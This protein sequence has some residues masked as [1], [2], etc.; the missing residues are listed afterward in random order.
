VGP[1]RY[2]KIAGDYA[3]LGLPGQ[4]LS[5]DINVVPRAGDVHATAQQTGLELYRLVSEA[6]RAF[7][8]I[9]FYSEGTIYRQDRGL[10]PG[11][12]ASTADVELRGGEATVESDQGVELEVGD[13]PHRVRMD[14]A[15]WPACN[16][17]AVLVP[18]GKHEIAWEA[19]TSEDE[20]FL[21]RDI[22]AVL[23]GASAEPGALTVRYK[24]PARAFLL[25][26]FRPGRVELDGSLAAPKVEENEHGFVLAAP[27]GEHTARLFRR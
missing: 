4:R 16:R 27:P 22:N 11:A 6:R 18:P 12:L 5:M 9:C 8:K 10:L 13:G 7:P 15:P 23:L 3:R 2:G 20:A 21:L 14:G 26:S 24:A 19:G 1:E 17:G 25:L